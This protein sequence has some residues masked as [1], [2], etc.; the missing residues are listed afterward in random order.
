M[1]TE[2]NRSDPQ[3]R[4]NPRRLHYQRPP[5]TDAQE[6]GG[7]EAYGYFGSVARNCS[8]AQTAKFLIKQVDTY[9]YVGFW[10]VIDGRNA[11]QRSEAVSL[12]G[13]TQEGDCSLWGDQ[14]SSYGGTVYRKLL[15]LR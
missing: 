5:E 3:P 11:R 9:R 14:I 7:A 13:A 6:A 15:I 12:Y 8:T 1:D 2:S 4:Q 10:K